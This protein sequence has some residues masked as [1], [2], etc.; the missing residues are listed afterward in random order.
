[1]TYQE[2]IKDMIQTRYQGNAQFTLGRCKEECLAMKEKFPELKEVPGFVHVEWF[3]DHD[4]E[5]KR[6][7]W[8]LEAPDGSIVDPTAG[9]FPVVL[10]YEP[11][12]DGMNVRI[13]TCMDCGNPIWGSPGDHKT[14]C[15]DNCAQSYLNYMNGKEEL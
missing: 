10:K 11:Y 7:H 3:T 6:E 4:R 13:G 5:N 8:W 14:F 9:Q 2:Y 15:N 12:V 1:M